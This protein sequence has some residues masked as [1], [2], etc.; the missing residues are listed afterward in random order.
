[1]IVVS[2]LRFRSPDRSGWSVMTTTALSTKPDSY[3]IPFAMRSDKMDAITEAIRIAQAL[4]ESDPDESGNL[5]IYVEEIEELSRSQVKKAGLILT[6]DP[7]DGAR[8]TLHLLTRPAAQG[9]RG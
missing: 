7:P 5:R 4:G 3:T 6:D 1:M 8:D 9:G 2:V